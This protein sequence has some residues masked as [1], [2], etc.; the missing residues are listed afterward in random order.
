MIKRNP[1]HVF[2]MVETLIN[3]YKDTIEEL[4]NVITTQEE[5]LSKQTLGI[6]GSVRFE[7]MKPEYLRFRFEAYQ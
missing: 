4:N 7:N 1:N 6:A 2:T 5:R 3:K